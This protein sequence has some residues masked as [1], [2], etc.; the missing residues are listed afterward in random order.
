MLTYV[1]C[2]CK[3]VPVIE[4]RELPADDW[5]LVVEEESTVLWIGAGTDLGTLLFRMN[6]TVADVRWL[7]AMK[8]E[9]P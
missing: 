2:G 5:R 3:R 4:T 1:F 8:I 6:C 9:A 7:Q